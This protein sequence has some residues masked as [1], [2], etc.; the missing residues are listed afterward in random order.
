MLDEKDMKIIGVLRNDAGLSMKDIGK[1]TGLRPSTVHQRIKKLKKDKVIEKFTVKLDS[2]A[3]MENF[4]VFMLVSSDKN[5]EDRIFANKH[6]K[7]VFGIT[8]EY[9]LFMKLKFK[10]VDEFNKFVIGFRKT[11][12]I[13]KT[14]TMVSTIA[15][16]EEL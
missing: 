16:K 6:V 8:G 10:D 13:K 15:L 12:G 11:Q 5:I 14:L 4:V 2:K 1:K 3:I 9:D 7:E